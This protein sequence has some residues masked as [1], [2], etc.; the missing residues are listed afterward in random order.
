MKRK[1]ERNGYGYAMA[2]R[3]G[4]NSIHP[5]IDNGELPARAVVGEQVTVA[6]TVF[7]EGHDAV[8]ASVIWRSPKGKQAP[9]NRLRPL[10]LGSDRWE[11]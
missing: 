8:A 4:L 5:L 3:L 10:G 9:F 6:A 7:R 1:K 2:G 11:T